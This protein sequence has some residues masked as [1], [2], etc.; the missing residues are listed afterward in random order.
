MSDT[1]LIKRTR[2]NNNFTIVNNNIL[3]DKTMSFEAKGMLCYILSLPD[4]WV[5]HTSHLI[6]E[7]NIGRHYLKR[8]F[9]EIEAAG[10][11]AKLG[12]IKGKGNRFEG[13]NYMFY[14]ESVLKIPQADFPHTDFPR[15]EE[16]HL[17]RT[18]IG[19]ELINTNNPLTPLKGE[20]VF[21]VDIDTSIKVWCDDYLRVCSAKGIR[22]SYEDIDRPK[23]K[24]KL[25]RWINMGRD[26]K[27]T[28][29]ALSNIANDRWQREHKLPDATLNKLFNVEV[30]AKWNGCISAKC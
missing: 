23:L 5:L 6:K 4:N 8:C 10:Y 9:D 25:E 13:F 7:F 27:E 29:L 12:M 26:P 28:I 19:K 15:A 21:F 2:R 14:D 24:K 1:N 16:Q 11:M 22:R 30:I 17:Q 3:R 20:E 18:N